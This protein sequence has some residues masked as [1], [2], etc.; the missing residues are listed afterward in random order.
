MDA[1]PPPVPR[2]LWF[3]DFEPGAV[4]RSGERA[5][6]QAEVEAFAELT[7]DRNPIHL[8]A[9]F[10]ARTPF[11]GRIA[12]GLLVESLASGLAWQL[13]IFR[14]TIVALSRIEIEFAAPVKPPAALRLVLRVLEREPDPGPKRGWVAFATDVENGSGEIVLRGKWY[15]VMQRRRMDPAG[16]SR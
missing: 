14:D 10:A 12:H 13:G 8:D 3:E 6:T 11:R 2:G 7:G 4:H 16:A 5:L 15:V 1:A 9:A